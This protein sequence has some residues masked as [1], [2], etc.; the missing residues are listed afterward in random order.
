MA[1]PKDKGKNKGGRPSKSEG[2]RRQ[3]SVGF[4]TNTAEHM[5]LMDKAMEAQLTIGEYC[6]NAAL[7]KRNPTPAPVVPAINRKAWSE[8]SRAA[9]NLNQIVAELK[10]AGLK[11][12]AVEKLQIGLKDFRAQLLGAG[13]E[14]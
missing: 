4:R 10:K 3:Y 1:Q 2:Q 12:G 7:G 11:S 9:S 14:K 8:L 5:E 13:G 6:R